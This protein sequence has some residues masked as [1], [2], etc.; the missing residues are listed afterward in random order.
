MAT[1]NSLDTPNGTVLVE[2]TFNGPA[3]VVLNSPNGLPFDI[4]VGSGAAGQLVQGYNNAFDGDGRL[5]IG[6]APLTGPT[7]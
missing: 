4:A 6:E 5:V 3:P 7:A 1:T 2:S